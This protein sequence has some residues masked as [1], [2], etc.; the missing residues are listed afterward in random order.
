MPTTQPRGRLVLGVVAAVLAPG[1]E[2]ST[3]LDDQEDGVDEGEGPAAGVRGML[4]EHRQQ[5]EDAHLGKGDAAGPSV[6]AAMQ[7][8]VQG[9]VDPRDPDQGEDDGELGQPADRDV[10]GQ[11]VGRLADDGHIDQVVNSSELLTCRSAMVSPCGRGGRRTS[12]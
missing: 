12:A 7:L 10:L 4:G 9:P 3:V 2:Q 8:Q 5:D 1:S 11:V 6:L